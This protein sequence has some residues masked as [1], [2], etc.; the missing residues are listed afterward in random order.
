MSF[1]LF[2]SLIEAKPQLKLRPGNIK[3][4]AC[5]VGSNNIK[6]SAALESTLDRPE[7]GLSEV[8]PADPP[9]PAVGYLRQ[10]PTLWVNLLHPVHDMAGP[11]DQHL[12]PKG[13]AEVLGD[14]FLQ[15]LGEVVE[16]VFPRTAA[17]T[18]AG[19]VLGT[20]RLRPKLV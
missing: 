19:I 5:G 8:E 2:K 6:H 15:A 1:I 20:A 3:P 9:V 18:G 11:Q 10:V 16:M 4:P 13:L 14:F 12:H 7:T 17:P